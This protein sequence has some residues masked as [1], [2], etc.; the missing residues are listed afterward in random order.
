MDNIRIDFAAPV[1]PVKPMHAVNNGPA[2]AVVRGTSNLEY[3]KDA[4]IPYCRFNDM[5]GEY[6]GGRYVDISIISFATGLSNEEIE[7]LK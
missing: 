7:K 1:G 6:G 4:G 2:G 5:S 3:F